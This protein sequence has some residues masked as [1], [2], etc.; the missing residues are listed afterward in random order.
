[1]PSRPENCFKQSSA[2]LQ[3]LPQLLAPSA[4]TR[5]QPP[6]HLVRPADEFQVV[7]LQELCDTVGAKGIAHAAVVL[8]P[9]LQRSNGRAR[10][11]GRHEMLSPLRLQSSVHTCACPRL[12]PQPLTLA[13]ELA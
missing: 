10:A 13:D 9:P 3:S 4:P 1:M 8:P 2:T 12:L 7:L 6:P 5:T 11:G